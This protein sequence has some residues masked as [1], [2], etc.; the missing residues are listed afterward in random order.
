M[1]HYNSLTI[2]MGVTKSWQKG[3][4]SVKILIDRFHFF[5]GYNLNS[6]VLFTELTVN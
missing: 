4:Y 3:A 6:D 5:I 1:T 2:T